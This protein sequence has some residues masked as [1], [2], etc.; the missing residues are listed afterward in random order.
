I[1]D[2]G[3]W[4]LAVTKVDIVGTNKADF[5]LRNI[6]QQFA[7]Q[8]DSSNSFIVDFLGTTPYQPA[9]R[10]AQ[11]IF[12]LDD[13]STFTVD[14]IEQ[15]I[16][17]IK[18]DLRMDNER[19][20]LGDIVYPCLRLKTDLPDSLRILDLKGVI[21]YDATLFDLDRT[22][23]RS[24][25]MVIKLGNWKLI[26]NAADLPGQF[27]YE[28]QGTGAPLSKAGSL[29]RL[30]FSPR[31][32]DP[33]GASSPLQN[34]QF[35]FPLRTE[36]NPL[37]T[38]AVLVVDSTC[39]SINLLSGAATAN[40]V[41]QNMP[42]PFGAKFGNSETQ[43]PFDIGFDNT[44]VTIRLLDVSGHEISRPVDN[45]L[46]NQGRYTVRVDASLISSSGMY[47]YEFRAGDAKP[48]YK[49]MMVSK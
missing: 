4:L 40:I 35:S 24:G 46:F 25:D 6:P 12:T 27:T 49:K 30:K 34:T 8:Q 28:L 33:L 16:E 20:R 45:V 37:I 39:G 14:L 44:T 48:V 29:L 26:S 19:A 41:D 32:S 13:G 7:I 36:L 11:I 21:T 43:I 3:N 38:D 9:A 18:V 1:S 15:D 2:S 10:T 22:G 5:T 17:P 31:N 47:F 42:N 23:I